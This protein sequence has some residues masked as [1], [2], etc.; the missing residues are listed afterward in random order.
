ML[1]PLATRPSRYVKTQSGSKS[2]CAAC[3]GSTYAY[4]RVYTVANIAEWLI[5]SPANLAEWEN[6]TLP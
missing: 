5:S 1:D 4:S 6:F 2:V 3:F